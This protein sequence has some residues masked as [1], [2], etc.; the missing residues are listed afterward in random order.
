[1]GLIITKNGKGNYTPGTETKGKKK[2][3]QI[4]DMAS[5]LQR[6][7]CAYGTVEG[8][9]HRCDCKFSYNNQTLKGY[10]HEESGCAEAR[11]IIRICNELLN[12]K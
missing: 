1:M 4:R 2:I 5:I 7:L 6:S 8:D 3:R 10:P 9:G 11:E 12:K